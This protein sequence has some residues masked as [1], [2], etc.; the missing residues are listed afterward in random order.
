MFSVLRLIG[1][2]FLSFFCDHSWMKVVKVQQHRSKTRLSTPTS[3][4]V[5]RVLEEW[6]L[7]T[8][9]GDEEEKLTARGDGHKLLCH[10]FP[11]SGMS[12]ETHTSNTLFYLSLFL[13][14]VLVSNVRVPE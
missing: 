4:P 1:F 8:P 12:K 11:Q 13:L 2:I 7:W 3:P 5:A 9:V 6:C 14:S 10:G